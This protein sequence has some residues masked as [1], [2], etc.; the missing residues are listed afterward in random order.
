[1]IVELTFFLRTI[2]TLVKCL[3][4]RTTVVEIQSLQFFYFSQTLEKPLKY[5]IKM[6]LFK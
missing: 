2:S 3:E 5:Y 6:L 1:M 4:N